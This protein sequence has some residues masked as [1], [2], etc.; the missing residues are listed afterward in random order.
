MAEIQ[1][2][3]GVHYNESLIKDWSKVICPP[4]DIIS[5]QD[6]QELHLVSEYNYI[7]IESGRE[8]PQDTATDNKYTRSSAL[9]HRWIE[10][11]VMRTD[12]APSLY[13]HD[14]HFSRRR[15]QYTRRNLISRV[16]LEEWST[17]VIRPHEGTLTEARGDRLSL[18]FAMQ[19]NTSP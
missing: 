14:H 4:Y 8:L 6:Q 13:L 5:P 9:F 10:E 11:G 15:K 1:P 3:R 7:R 19:A 18:L 2:F 17:M 16:R 12:D